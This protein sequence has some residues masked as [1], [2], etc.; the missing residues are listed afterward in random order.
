MALLSGLALKAGEAGFNT[1]SSIA[2]S[3]FNN[4]LQRQNQERIWEREDSAITRRL[5]DAVT[6]G[7]M[8]GVNP[9][10]ALGVQPTPTN[11]VQPSYAEAPQ[12]SGLA[13]ASQTDRELDIKKKGQEEQFKI[14]WE[15]L[16]LKREQFENAK[17]EFEQE[18]TNANSNAEAER[19]LTKYLKTL[20]LAQQK[21]IA[22]AQND[23]Q[24]EAIAKQ[25]EAVQERI[26]HEQSEGDLNRQHETA[27][28]R[29]QRY[30]QY[31]NIAI[32]GILGLS[33]EIRSWINPFA[34]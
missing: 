13:E 24:K 20:E 34:K 9:L 26:K 1:L 15:E 18:L 14:M 19:T 3:A 27:E 28:N 33:K 23:T 25:F 7:Q 30:V 31:A 8:T 4:E 6:G 12:I 5:Q 17:K 2:T 22:D 32:N 21:M 29:K 10:V 11:I 16:G